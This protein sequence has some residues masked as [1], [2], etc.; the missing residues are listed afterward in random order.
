M[1]VFGYP[2]TEPRDELNQDTGKHYRTQWFER[3]RFE[4]HP[5]NRPPYDVLLGRLG[6][7]QFAA[8]GLPATREAGPKLGCLWFP[9]TSHTVCDQAQARGF[10]WYWQTHGLQDPQL[11][12]ISKVL[13]CSDIL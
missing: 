7:D 4:Y 12:A 11:S 8:N 2:L 13:P 6:A 5:E 1:P 3:A 9:Q 10:K